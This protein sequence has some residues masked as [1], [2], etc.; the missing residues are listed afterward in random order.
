MYR[1]MTRKN[2]LAASIACALNA[3]AFAQP[4]EIEEIQ[5]IGQFVPDEK[6]AT[7]AVS[8]VIGEEQFTRSGDSNIAEGL[9]RVAGLSTV[10]GKFVYVRGLG[11]RYST[12][13]LNGAVLPSPE[14]L[15]RVVPMDL[16]PTAVLESVLVQKTYSAQYPS[17]FGG[18]VLQLRTKKSTDEFFW[19]V[20][21]TL[22]ATSNVTFNDGFTT[23]GGDLAWAG[24]D[25]GYRDLPDVLQEATAGG[26]ELRRE[27]RFLPGVGYSPA[28]LQTIGRSLRN[29]YIPDKDSLPANI[30][31]STSLGNFH[32]IGDTGAKVNY[33]AA[34]DYSNSWNHN[35]IVRKTYKYSNDGLEI[36]DDGLFEGTE[37]SVDISSIFTAGIDFNPN[38]NIRATSVL[39]RKTDDRVSEFNGEIAAEA[40]VRINQMEW[41]ERELFSN[42]LQGDHYFPEFNELVINWRYSKVKAERDS[43][44]DREYK[45]DQLIDT[46]RFSTRADGNVRRWSVLDDDAEDYAVDLTMVFYGPMNS[47]ITTQAGYVHNDKVRDSEIRRYAFFD[48]GPKAFDQELLR[49]PLEEVLA[50]ENIGPDGFEL[51]EF[52]RPTDNYEASNESDSY[53]FQGEINFDERL[54]LSAGVR[55]EE[56]SQNVRTF[57]LFRDVE[58]NSAQESDELLP[59]FSATFINYDHQFRLAYSETQSRPD[60]RELSPAGFTNPINGREVVGNPDLEIASIKNYDF[61]WEWY[62]AFGDYMSL[63]MFYKD[64]DQPIES[65]IQAGADGRQTYTNAAG[66]E[67]IGAEWEIFKR[68]DFLG[69]QWEDWYIQSNIAY[70]DSEVQIAEE[71]RG[72]LT[73]T[74]RAL[75]GQSDLLFNLQIGYEPFSGTTATLLYHYFG[76]RISE[77]GIEGAPDL[78]EEDFGELNFVFIRE[79]NENWRAQFKARNILDEKS[80]ITQGGLIVNSFNRG[81]GVSFQVDYTF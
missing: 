32:E 48:Q 20:N 42:Q 1:L 59:A 58:I 21:S 12:T 77:V 68:L 79:L 71:D 11:E 47:T 67:N 39:L 56:F 78:I 15:N 8:N 24:Y 50:A 75:Q 54:R 4:P 31:F 22:G 36:E 2:L 28:E 40:I 81:V 17:E 6:R 76:D 43:P 80:E 51:R 52:T 57:D 74:S 37:H 3:T 72:V 49:R 60:F 23:P 30:D 14:P 44:D 46:L 9:K 19:N 63:G 73:N 10:G 13:L 62:F 61:R 26:Q 41:V 33:L 64:F 55:R 66:G 70:I 34:I 16:F 29:E 65:V 35:E 38:H 45:Y 53:Y 5:V 7:S 18:G 27:S 25:D 69:G